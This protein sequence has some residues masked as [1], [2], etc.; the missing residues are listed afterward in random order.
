M[1]YF[2]DEG[3]SLFSSLMAGFQSERWLKSELNSPQLFDGEGCE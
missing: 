1:V 2:F 3:K